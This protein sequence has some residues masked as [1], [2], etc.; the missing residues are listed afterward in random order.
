MR[1]L[2]QSRGRPPAGSLEPPEWFVRHACAVADVAAWLA[3][4]RRRTG[5]AVDVGAVEAA[6]LL[7]DVD[8]LPGARPL[9]DLRHGDGSAAWLAA[10]GHRG[11]RAAGP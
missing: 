2:M 10:H 6:A 11:A 9:P 7:H 1:H 4:G 8:K 5:A 3:A